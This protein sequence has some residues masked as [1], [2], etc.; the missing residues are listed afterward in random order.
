MRTFLTI[1]FSSAVLATSLTARAENRLFIIGNN[2]GY[3]VDRCLAANAQC[4][5]AIA[6]AFCRGHEFR[7]AVSYRKVDRD[8][9]TGTVPTH[10]GACR[11]GV[12]KDF[13][14][15]ECTR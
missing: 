9:I 12:C 10:R 5:S 15:I 8:D 13:L 1:A 4:G 6:T 3:G 2:A 11:G 7:H 14:A